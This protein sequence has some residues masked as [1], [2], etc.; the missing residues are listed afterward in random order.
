MTGALGRAWRRWR[1]EGP[2]GIAAA[3]ADRVEDVRAARLDRRYAID[4][5][6]EGTRHEPIQVHAFH[7]IASRLPPP[8]NRAFVDYGAGKGRALILAAEAG[9]A[10]VAGVECDPALHAVA[11][12]NLKSYRAQRPHAGAIDITLGDAVAYEPPAGDAVL[13]FYNPFGAEALGAVLAR[14]RALR[15]RSDAEWL[16][17]YR[18]AV[19]AALVEAEDWLE[20]VVDRPDFRIWRTRARRHRDAQ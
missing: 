18:T 3:L 14:L 19:H 5:R 6:P 4:T 17:A 9:F 8:G 2:A 12:A 10:R 13:F 15:E 1:A 7:A 11:R 20:P 16:L